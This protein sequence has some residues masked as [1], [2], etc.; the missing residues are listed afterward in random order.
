MEESRKIR[1]DSADFQI[2][3]DKYIEQVNDFKEYLKE[4][5]K[6][7][8]K[9]KSKKN[10]KADSYSRY[11]IRLLILYYE[12]YNEYIND[13]DTFESL[14]KLEGITRFT[15]FKKLNSNENH[16]YSATFRSYKAYVS[17]K[18]ELK[19]EFESEKV[20]DYSQTNVN[21]NELI[22]KPQERND[23]TYNYSTY[24]RNYK[25]AIAAKQKSDWK[26]EYN[27]N[28]TTFINSDNRKPFVESHHL[29]PMYVQDYFDNTIDFADNIVSLCPNCHKKIHHGLV[30]E[31]QEMIETLYAKRKD[32][33]V[34]Y[35]IKID[36][37][38]LLIYYSIF[39]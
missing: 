5:A 17:K 33:Y 19:H 36:I 4:I 1:A 2:F 9:I 34:L 39:V 26:C 11:L 24:K 22:Q 38:E 8:E 28:H 6:K 35:G 31:K 15:E 20:D 37:K 25:E 18:Q 21:A 32:Y 13:I 16:F 7:N 27:P 29:V 12:E 23:I 3:K 30:E 14:K 10:G